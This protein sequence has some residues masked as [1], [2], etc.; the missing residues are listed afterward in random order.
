M[1]S[2]MLKCFAVVIV[3]STVLSCQKESLLS[4]SNSVA[5]SSARIAALTP[6]LPTTIYN[7]SSIVL[8][9][10]LTNPQ[11]EARNNTPANNPITDNGATL[12]RVLFFDK[13][14]SANNTT[15]C[16]SCHQQTNSFS[17]PVRFSKG[18][19][20]GL[21][22]RNSMSLI[23][24]RYYQNGRFFWDERAASAEAQATM[25]IVHPVEMGLTMATLLTKLKTLEY[26]PPLFQKAFGTTDIDSV[27]VARSLAQFVRSIVSYRTKYDIG[28]AALRQNQNPNNTNFTNFT[29]QENQGR[30]IFF[31]QG[32]CA[33]CHGTD[34]FTAPGVRNNGLDL[35]SA[36]N[37]VGAITG[38]RNQNAL[39][40]VPSLRGIEKS[41]PYMHDGRFQTLEQVVEHYSSQVKAHPN[42]SAQLRGQNG[43]PRLLNLTVAEKASLVAFLKTLTDTGIETD[44]KYSD[45]FK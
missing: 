28:R 23:D 20:G 3:S 40:K 31:N 35:V 26:Y 38:S 19:N 24:A 18:F 43:R 39:F 13:N 2:K 17:D 12:G 25:P 14:L 44:T 22:T 41:A 5:T 30:Q 21:T 37:G 42:L 27:R 6:I 7:Y 36:D 34:T 8:P 4:E 15:S 33:A 10:Y 11:N 1:K 16:G 32:N 45:P 29:A 9:N